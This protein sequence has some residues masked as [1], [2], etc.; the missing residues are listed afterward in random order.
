MLCFNPLTDWWS[1]LSLRLKHEIFLFAHYENEIILE[2]EKQVNVLEDF[3][4]FSN[5]QLN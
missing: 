3:I 1:A 5:F 4:K 2:E